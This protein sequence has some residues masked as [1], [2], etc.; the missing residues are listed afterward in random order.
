MP[1]QAASSINFFTRGPASLPDFQM[2]VRKISEVALGCFIL[3]LALDFFVNGAGAM[4]AFT[5]LSCPIAWITGGAVLTITLLIA[6]GAYIYHK[7]ESEQRYEDEEKVQKLKD[8]AKNLSFYQLCQIHTADHLVNHIFNKEEGDL[9]KQALQ[10]K[11][12]KAT[13][14]Y[15]D[16]ASYNLDALRDQGIIDGAFAE[17]AREIQKKTL[18][19]DRKYREG[20]QR[21]N[22]QYPNRKARKD[23][24]KGLLEYPISAA[25]GYFAPGGFLGTLFR[26][27]LSM[28]IGTQLD[29][30]FSEDCEAQTE[31]LT[32][33][34]QLQILQKERKES[35]EKLKAKYQTLLDPEPQQPDN[36]EFIV[37]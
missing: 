34:E 17:K 24:E 15:S 27:P 32:Y 30:Q 37:N 12:K 5:L 1:A 6:G 7:R 23:R 18:K 9:S 20:L 21:I 19:I 22:E 31:Q 11:F 13:R 35:Q 28:F 25:C 2:N 16:I 4:V 10:K 33:D 29:S 26:I 36:E 8:E 14:H 3:L